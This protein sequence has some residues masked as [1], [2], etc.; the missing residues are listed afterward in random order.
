MFLLHPINR[1]YPVARCFNARAKLALLALISILL[2]SSAASPGSLS[3]SKSS[4]AQTP[5]VPQ[6]NARPEVVMI[7]TRRDFGEVFA[8]EELE[9]AFG[10][11]NAGTAPLELAQKSSLGMRPGEPAFPV[12]AAWHA[13]DVLLTRSVAAMR[14][15]PT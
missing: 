8:G 10:V 11:R 7:A 6:A 9:A 14:V 4:R 13:N 3:E 2:S 12:S 15:A 1:S 5:S